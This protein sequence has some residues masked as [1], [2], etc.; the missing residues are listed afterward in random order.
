MV[1]GHYILVVS[2][3][4]VTHPRRA[5]RVKCQ[6]ARGTSL[7]LAT[8]RRSLFECVRLYFV[9]NTRMDELEG[10]ISITGE[11]M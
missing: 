3:V 6:Q 2:R 8:F 1:C 5:F 9:V 11:K 4:S 7:P 10:S